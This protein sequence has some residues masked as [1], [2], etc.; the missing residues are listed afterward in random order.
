MARIKRHYHHKKEQELKKRLKVI[1]LVTFGLPLFVLCLFVFFGPQVGAIFGFVSVNRNDT[2]NK[3]TIAPIPPV[4][5]NPPKATKDKSM[6]L[7]GF[8]E[9][10]STVKL[11]VNGPE[12]QDTLTTTDGTFAFENIEL[13]DGKNSLFAKATDEQGNESEKSITL[14]VQVDN[15]EPDITIESPKDDEVIRNLNG[16]ITIKGSVSEKAK[17]KINGKSAVQ[18]PDLSFEFPLGV[19]EGKLEITVEATDEA[20]NIKEEKFFVTYV[21]GS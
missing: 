19:G 11:F 17:I 21:K 4:F 5:D 3:D 7:S 12:T 15:D 14:S 10:G 18:R 13:I 20:G 9:P 8:S 2:G 6:K 16:R 1:L